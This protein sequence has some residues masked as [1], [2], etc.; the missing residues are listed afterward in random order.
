MH[1]GLFRSTNQSLRVPPQSHWG[2]INQAKATGIAKLL[3][4]RQAVVE[5]H[6]EF[7]LVGAIKRWFGR[8][9]LTDQVS[10]GICDPPGLSGDIT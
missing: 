8:I 2:Q 4:L 1:P 10:M 3:E 5:S 7:G 6:D 9:G